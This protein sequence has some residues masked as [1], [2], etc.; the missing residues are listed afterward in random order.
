MKETMF[1]GHTRFTNKAI[2]NNIEAAL[3]R[4]EKIIK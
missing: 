1:Y 3:Q 2:S 4:I